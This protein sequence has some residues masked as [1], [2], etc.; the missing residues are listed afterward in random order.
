MERKAMFVRSVRRGSDRRPSRGASKKP[1]K[2]KAAAREP[3]RQHHLD[4]I[5]LG[6]VLLGIYLVFVLYFGWNGGRLGSG[7]SDGLMYTLGLVAYL[8]PVALFAAGAVAI[9]RPAMPVTR[10]LRLGSALLLAGLLLAFA[11]GTVG[12]GGGRLQGAGFFR[13]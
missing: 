10:P 13:Q 11:G 7:I 12:L 3:L 9:F 2:A 1:T 8:V 4:L 5:G 6:S